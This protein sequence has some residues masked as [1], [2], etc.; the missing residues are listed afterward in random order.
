MAAFSE[1]CDQNSTTPVSHRVVAVFC[2]KSVNL[3]GFWVSAHTHVCV[4]VCMHTLPPVM[5]ELGQSP[6]DQTC[7]VS[8]LTRQSKTLRIC[9]I[10]RCYC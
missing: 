9:T 5:I 7:C 1:T 6:L 4:S 3:E 2:S 10:N 8:S